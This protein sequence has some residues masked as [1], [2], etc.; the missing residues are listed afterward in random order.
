MLARPQPTDSLLQIDGAR[1]GRIARA[2]KRKQPF[3]R[4]RA[5]T[6]EINHDGRVQQDRCQLPDATLVGSTLLTYPSA[7]I[8][9][10]LMTAVGD[11]A[12]SRLE[13]LPAVVVLKRPLDSTCD[14][15]AATPGAYATVQLTNELIRE[16]NVHSH[17]HNLTHTVRSRVR[18]RRLSDFGRADARPEV[19]S[20][21]LA[22]AEQCRISANRTNPP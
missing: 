19:D 8:V 20:S 12:D 5:T 22:G 10:P 1:V 9:V 2:T 7:C 17:G 11:R 6:K 15:C 3:P 21:H 13:E 4:V 18:P 16:S 14:I